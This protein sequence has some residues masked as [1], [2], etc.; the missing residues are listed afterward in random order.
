M[1]SAAL[2]VV[3]KRDMYE[4]FSWLAMNVTVY[5]PDHRHFLGPPYQSQS[6]RSAGA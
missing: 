2:D 6:F 5:L 1:R 4:Y 3:V